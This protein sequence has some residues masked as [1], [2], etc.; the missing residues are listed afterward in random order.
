M[1]QKI[2]EYLASRGK[3]DGYVFVSPENEI[4]GWKETIGYTDCWIPGTR[5][6]DKKGNRWLAVGGSCRN[7]AEKW[8][9]I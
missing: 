6:V 5:A 1:K 4:Y 2:K 8:E 7:G 9:A 3:T